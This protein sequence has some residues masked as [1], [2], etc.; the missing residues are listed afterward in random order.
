LTGT[1]TYLA[2][3]Q[4]R[5]CWQNKNDRP[6]SINSR[7]RTEVRARYV[8]LL[9]GIKEPWESVYR[10]NLQS[11]KEMRTQ[12]HV[13]TI[14]LRP[15]IL[16]ML[17]IGST[18]YRYVYYYY[19]CYC[20]CCNGMYIICFYYLLLSMQ[21]MWLFCVRF[22]RR[23]VI[24]FRTL[25]VSLTTPAA[26]SGDPIPLHNNNNNNNNDGD[27]RDNSMAAHGTNVAVARTITSPSHND[28]QT[29]I[30]VA[31]NNNITWYSQ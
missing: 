24:L 25:A 14:I 11:A 15:I 30:S 3:Y 22:L 7:T 26:V 18:A 16:P 10:C 1:R 6:E 8:S 13:V 5:R 4:R 23:T 21:R 27:D 29:A 17:L 12:T 28:I 9:V 20:F 19:R 31:D 2:L